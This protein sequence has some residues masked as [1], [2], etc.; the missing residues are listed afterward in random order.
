MLPQCEFINKEGP[1]HAL[2]QVPWVTDAVALEDILDDYW[3]TVTKCQSWQILNLSWLEFQKKSSLHQNLGREFSLK[4]QVLRQMLLFHVVPKSQM[5]K[6]NQLKLPQSV[7]ISISNVF[8]LEPRHHSIVIVIW[9][10]SLS[11][12]STPPPSCW[13]VFQ[14]M[15]EANSRHNPPFDDHYHHHNHPHRHYDQHHHH[16]RWCE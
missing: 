12:L 9:N 11:S 1:W 10:K 15:L 16:I 6:R 2:W 4:K 14:T 13:V 3:L 8:N 5:G 7:A